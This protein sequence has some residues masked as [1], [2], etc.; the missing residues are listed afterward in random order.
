M[1]KL[2]TPPALMTELPYIFL[3][4]IQLH[5]AI[6]FGYYQIIITCPVE[7]NLTPNNSNRHETRLFFNLLRPLQEIESPKKN[8]SMDQKLPAK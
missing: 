3:V 2:S 6:L 5:T 7:L 8:L 1:S 4:I